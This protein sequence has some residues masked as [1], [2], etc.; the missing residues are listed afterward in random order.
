[1]LVYH[2]ILSFFLSLCVYLSL[3]LSL[4]ELQQVGTDGCR[5]WYFAFLC[6]SLCLS[7]SLFEPQ[8]VGMNGYGE[9]YF[10]KRDKG[11]SQ[12]FSA[13]LS[14]G[15][16]AESMESVGGDPIDPLVWGGIQIL[17]IVLIK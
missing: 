6:L 1:V 17:P 4:F 2:G 11:S 7:V 13:T 15:G 9:L 12:A 5:E 8:Q 3:S 10:A 14:K 16:K